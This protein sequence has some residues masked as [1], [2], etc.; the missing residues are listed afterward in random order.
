[1]C[2]RGTDMEK[3][4][5][6][7]NSTTSQ[8]QNLIEKTLKIE[9]DYQYIQNIESNRTLEKEISEKIKKIIDSGISE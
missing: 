4:A 3:P 7:L 9:K 1:M 6:I 8:I 2:K 5:D